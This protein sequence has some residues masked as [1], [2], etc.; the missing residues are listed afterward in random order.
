MSQ[1]F[2]DNTSTL[3]GVLTVLFNMT[4]FGVPIGII[5]EVVY[6][7][8]VPGLGISFIFG[9]TY[10]TYLSMRRSKQE[11]RAFTAQ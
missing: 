9:N 1:L 3:L 2:F 7:K 8:I 4:F 5:N 6:K 11:G 10:Y